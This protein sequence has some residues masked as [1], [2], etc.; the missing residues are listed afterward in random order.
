MKR[1]PSPI[2]LHDPSGLKMCV[3]CGR[4]VE[5]HSSWED[6]ERRG[7]DPG[8]ATYP[9]AWIVE[10]RPCGHRFL[11][12]AS[13]TLLVLPPSDTERDAVLAVER[14]SQGSG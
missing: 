8:G 1:R 13:F 7:I 14:E 3:E 11:T 6:P 5:H 10:L 12:Q 2:I 4:V 9:M